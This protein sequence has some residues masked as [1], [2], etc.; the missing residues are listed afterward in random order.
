[1]SKRNTK[2][3]FANVVY[4]LLILIGLVIILISIV[5]WT[6]HEVSELMFKVNLLSFSIGILYIIFAL[7]LKKIKR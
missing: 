1:M 5:S 2:N 6:P 7:T 3:R 4:A